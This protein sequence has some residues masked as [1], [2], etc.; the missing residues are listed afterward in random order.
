[1]K[2]HILLLAT[3]F[4]L[5]LFVFAEQPYNKVIHHTDP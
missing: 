2:N 1:M 5:F 3:F 4:L